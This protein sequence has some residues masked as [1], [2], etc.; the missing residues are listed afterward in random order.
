M[1]PPAPADLD[2][3]MMAS[4][5]AALLTGLS[6]AEL[7]QIP[8]DQRRAIVEAAVELRQEQ[9]IAIGVA[10]AEALLES[11]GT[12]N[13]QEGGEPWASATPSNESDCAPPLP[14][15]RLAP[16]GAVIPAPTMAGINL[17]VPVHPDGTPIEDDV[18]ELLVAAADEHLDSGRARR[19]G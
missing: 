4:A 10:C 9:A 5:R 17:A 14:S 8:A 2:P 18:R 6:L 1:I 16:T 7:T 12:L 15:T 3:Q 13:N 11:L 19:I